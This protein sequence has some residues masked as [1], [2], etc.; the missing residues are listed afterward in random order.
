VQLVWLPAALRLLAA[1]ANCRFDG[2][3]T[4]IDALLGCPLALPDRNMF[5][6]GQ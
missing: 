5:A 4:N 3:M 6:D 2:D 1:I